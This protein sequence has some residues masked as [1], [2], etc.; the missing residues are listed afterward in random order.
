MHTAAITSHAAFT[1]SPRVNATMPREIVPSRIT[2]AQISLSRKDMMP[3]QPEAGPI[4]VC[5]VN[6]EGTSNALIWIKLASEKLG[7]RP[8]NS[9]IGHVLILGSRTLALTGVAHRSSCADHHAP[10][11]FTAT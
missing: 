10:F 6:Q 11:V 8:T 2:P 4:M 3:R 5:A 1:G 7:L 9:A